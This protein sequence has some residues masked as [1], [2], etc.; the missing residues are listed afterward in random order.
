MGSGAGAGKVNV[1]DLSVTKY[2]DK[3]IADADAGLLQR[4]AHH[5]GAS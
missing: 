2:I 3:S 5:E 1:Q 4:Q